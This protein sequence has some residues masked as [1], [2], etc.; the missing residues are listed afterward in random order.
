[1]NRKRISTIAL[2]L[3]SVV[4]IAAI[5]WIAGSTI[6]SPAEAAIRTAPPQPSPILV[7]VEERVLAAK[8]V[9]RGTARFGLPQSI[10]MA[11]SML[12]ADVGV[13]TTLPEQGATFQEGDM[14]LTASGR[15]LFVLYG[16]SPMYRDLT[17]GIS[18]ADVR[19]L[20]EALMRLG[21]EPGPVDGLY[22]KET[23]EAVARLYIDAGWKPFGPTQEQLDQIQEALNRQKAAERTVEAA[24]TTAS[25][26]MDNLVTHQAQ[27]GIQIPV[28]Q[29]EVEVGDS[30][31]GPVLMVTN[32]QVAID[33]SLA[34]DT[35][36]L[37]KPGMAVAIDEPD[38]GIEATGVV[39]RV[40][41]R[42]GTDGADGYHVYFETL[43]DE[44]TT[45]LDGFSLRLTIPTES[46]DGAVTTVPI[47]ALSLAPDGSSRVQIQQDDLLTYITVEPGFS[48]NGFVEVTASEG[49]LEP[50][51]LVVIG[52]EQPPQEV[53]P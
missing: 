6:Q 34:L 50:G 28:D 40:A 16:E 51:Q 26:I 30:A 29:I 14:L 27:N 10:V 9:T 37:V 41:D 45:S 46:S 33:A 4:L 1:M 12:K 7:P 24:T 23:S 52:F 47:S 5:S 15:P 13:I 18:G 35:A 20:E 44:T 32:N 2:L 36:L 3:G 49:A 11:P 19:Q 22:D 8:I 48:A 53:L 38:L 39:E 42:P 25:Q 43:V 17:P 31:A 21:L